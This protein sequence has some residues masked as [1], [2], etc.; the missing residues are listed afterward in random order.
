MKRID[1]LTDQGDLAH[2]IVGETLDVIDD[3]RNRPRDFRAARIGH[4][5]ER[6]EFVAAFLHGDE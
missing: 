2:A 5:T 6:A 3:L 4:D 1:V